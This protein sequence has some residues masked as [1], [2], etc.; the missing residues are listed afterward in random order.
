[1]I[2]INTLFEKNKSKNLM[3]RIIEACAEP[4]Y[5]EGQALKKLLI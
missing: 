3:Q 4:F 1:V 2:K 5:F